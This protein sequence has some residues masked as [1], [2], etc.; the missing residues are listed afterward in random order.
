MKAQN[1]LQ[2]I[3]GTP[4]VRIQRLFGHA[5]QEVW[6]K[7]ERANPGGSIKDR[8][9]LSMV[10]DAE[11]SG[12]LKPGGTIVEPT[13]GNTGIGLAMVAAVKGYKLVLV[14]PDSM[15][16]ERRR[17]MLAYGA[18][19]DL[20]PREK[21]M[22]GCIAR[23]EEILAG[24]PGAWMPQQFDN[25][26][27]VE[28]HARTT[29][30]EIAADFP[31]GIDA[32]IT[33]VGTGG[34][35]TGCAQVLKKKWPKLKVFAVEPVASPVISGG[36]PSPHPIQGI[37]AGFIPKNLDTELLDGV[38]QVDAEPAREMARRCAAEE[39]M[40]VGISSGATLTAIAQK[41]PELA[42]DAVVLGFNYDTGE[43]YLSVE[44]FLPA[45]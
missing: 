3:G 16:V 2:T 37:G 45:A 44:G 36:A 18:S 40:L 43:R 39:G 34:H 27:N 35:I 30:E 24:T 25:P 1:I 28:V 32:L 7:C 8:I 41:L 21:G 19:F 33:G 12:A 23:A 15:S 17:L 31:D 29:A 5:T 38:I 11:R 10:E 42:R 4:H 9:A 26:A 6:I 22:K 13:S 14:M 20:T